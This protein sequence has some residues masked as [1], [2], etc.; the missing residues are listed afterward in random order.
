MTH[1]LE[2]QHQCKKEREK[3]YWLC[4]ET[5]HI[6]AIY[7]WMWMETEPKGVT[8]EHHE[9]RNDWG[10]PRMIIMALPRFSLGHQS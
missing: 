9:M 1:T 4:S 10:M 8:E 2:L 7:K 3:D 5:S 6:H